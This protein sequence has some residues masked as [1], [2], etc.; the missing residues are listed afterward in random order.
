M[1][2]PNDIEEKLMKEHLEI[3]KEVTD[4][5]KNLNVSPE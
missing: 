1:E 5:E 3:E 2:I 4:M